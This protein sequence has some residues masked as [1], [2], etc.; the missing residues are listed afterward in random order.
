MYNT[1]VVVVGLVDDSGFQEK[2]RN[3]IPFGTRKGKNRGRKKK[4]RM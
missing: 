4:R 1:K 2:R 3:E